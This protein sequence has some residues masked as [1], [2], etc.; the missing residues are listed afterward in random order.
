MVNNSIDIKKRT[1]TS[2]LNHWIQ[3]R[4]QHTAFEI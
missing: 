2:H 4:P 1:T 3:K